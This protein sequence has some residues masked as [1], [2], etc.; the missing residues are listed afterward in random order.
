MEFLP[1]HSIFRI[2][3]LPRLGNGSINPSLDIKENS[4]F[5]TLTRVLNLA[6]LTFEARK[7]LYNV[8]YLAASLAYAR[9]MPSA[10]AVKSKNVS[11]YCQMSL[12]KKFLP[13]TLETL[14]LRKSL[15]YEKEILDT[16]L[17]TQNLHFPSISIFQYL[18]TFLVDFIHCLSY[19]HF[20]A[21]CNYMVGWFIDLFLKFFRPCWMACGISVTPTRDWTRAI[22]VN[23]LNPYH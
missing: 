3:F 23:A 5:M 8:G 1:F 20:P 18:K 15:K 10:P 2:Q 13:P 19:G 17:K 14:A 21:L 9:W 16:N 11:W 4:T 22:A 12:R 7:F 6:L